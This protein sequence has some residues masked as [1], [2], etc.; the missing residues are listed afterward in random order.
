MNLS[1]LGILR[2]QTDGGDGCSGIIPWNKGKVLLDEKYKS[3]RKNKGRKLTFTEE[4]TRNMSTS[5][6]GKPKS[7]EHKR[8]LS[9]AGKGNEPWNK[10]LDKNDPRVAEYANKLKGKEFSE[11]H[12][13]KLS[14]SHKGK[15]N[16]PEQK[17]KISATLTGRV[18]S[19]ETKKK[20][21]EAR[22]KL[23]AEKKKNESR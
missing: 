15:K 14:E 22:K 7:E 23:W 2:N 6:K 10:G 9:E 5:N 12:R 13:Q 4:H 1:N 19:E 11:E 21:S 16:T 18:K 17:A 20:M 3:G 8:K